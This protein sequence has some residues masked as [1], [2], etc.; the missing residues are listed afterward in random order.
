MQLRIR[1]GAAIDRSMADAFNPLISSARKAK[2]AIES[3]SRD[4][5]KAVASSTKRGVKDAEKAY[6]DWV[7]EIETG[8]PKAFKTGTKAAEDFSRKTKA[9]FDNTKR[10]FREFARDA[11]REMAKTE[12]AL[13]GAGTKPKSL[14]LDRR[15]NIDAAGKA[16][17]SGGA[18]ASRALG[19]AGGLAYG[20]GRDIVR[21]SGL[22]VDIGGAIQSQVGLEARMTELS[23]AAYM[24]GAAGAAGRRQDPRKL[25]AEAQAV[26][27]ATAFAPSEAG[28]AL[29]KFV[30][31]TGDLETGR[32][33]LLEMAKAARV[34]GA[35]LD[36][37]VD[38][39][40]DVKSA[41]GD[42]GTAKEI[43]VV[44]RTIA[45]QG[46]LG[47]V[48]V[49][50]LAT[51]MAK[52]SAASQTFSGSRV[53][54]MGQMGALAQMSRAKGGSASATQAATSVASF[55]NLFSKSARNAAFE[56]FGLTDLRDTKGQID[57]RKVLVESMKAASSEKHGG[58]AKFD[59]NMGK[60]FADVRARSVTKGFEGAFREAGG[61]EAGAK[62]VVDAFD[63]LVRSTMDNAEMNES[64]ARSM[65]TSEAKAQ[66]FQNEVG[67]VAVELRQAMLPAIVALAPL[68]LQ[69]AKGVADFLA[70]ITG[71][72]YEQD[73]KEA[74]RAQL[75]ALN[76]S[77]G[78][79]AVSGKGAVNDVELKAA[80]EEAR[81]ARADLEKAIS[82]KQKSLAEEEGAGK[83]KGLPGVVF[84]AV[85][86]LATRG[87]ESAMQSKEAERAQQDRAALA[88]MQDTMA[89]MDR[90][91]SE[92][93]DRLA[94]K[95]LK[96]VV[97]G[98]QRPADPTD[99]PGRTA[100]PWRKPR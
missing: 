85:S 15:A 83:V 97:V 77:G 99:H 8:T 73:D 25:M 19:R 96:V 20:V 42:A 17:G 54:V 14:F 40:G 58:M 30:A 10:V 98:D 65:S 13:K 36:D 93:A 61:G 32:G 33:I 60:M 63:A 87:T 2:T 67:K 57:V 37:M 72:K 26:G 43:G 7:Q 47:A 59:A 79:L 27:D 28:A 16:I 69:A 53:E 29:S 38:A 91:S 75:A 55:S 45:A 86:P 31:K 66:L 56:G 50:D 49:K 35:S 100:P 74:L 64:F 39:A 68:F 41:L 82:A 81:V 34:T 51:Q 88:R 3:T 89:Q 23:N 76:A 52:L 18:M 71:S 21:G 5:A 22:T 9:S 1:V 80:Q 90:R 48:E 62:A 6:R 4:G 94:N 12:K 11:E 70:K 84:E 46:K 92:L 44:M 24:P 78:I 95:T